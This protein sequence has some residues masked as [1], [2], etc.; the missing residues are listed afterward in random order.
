M[1][2]VSNRS[3]CSCAKLRLHLG[4][5]ACFSILCA[6]G[7]V[8]RR[9]IWAWHGGGRKH[10]YALYVRARQ[11]CA[12]CSSSV[13]AGFR[14]CCHFPFKK[15]KGGRLGS[16]LVFRKELRGMWRMRYFQEKGGEGGTLSQCSLFTGISCLQSEERASEHR[17]RCREGF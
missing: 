7:D 13:G 16:S 3:V 2:E 15:E 1:A 11:H 9:E 12:P 17:I 10:Y 6:P 8:K 5:G 14:S 4:P